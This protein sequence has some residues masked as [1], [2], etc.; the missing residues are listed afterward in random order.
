MKKH[1]LLILVIILITHNVNAQKISEEKTTRWR[2]FE[3]IEF[4]LDSIAAWYVKPKSSIKGNPWIWRAHFPTWHTE[5]DSILLERGFHVAYINTNNLYAHPKAM[6]VWDKFYNYLVNQKNFAP[7][8]ALEGVSRGALYVY[9]WAKRNPDK[10][11]CIYT[12]AAVC[13]FKSWPA[14]KGK[15]KRAVNEWNK[16]LELYGFTEEQ[17]M[18]FNDQ[19]K[20]NL[21]TLA[22]FRVPL[23]HIINLK[24]SIV[25]NEENTF[26]LVNNYL[27]HGG[28][29]TVIP[30]TRGEQELNGH[31]FEIENPQAL[32]DFIY[33]H[34]VPV[35]QLLKS[36]D[37]IHSYGNLNNALFKIQKE[38][39]VTVAF[40][41]GSITNMNGWRNK[42]MQY[43]QELFPQTKFS[44]INA[45]IPSLGSMPHAFRLQR[46]VLDKGKVDLMFIEAAVN[47]KANKTPEL[48]QR[49]ALEG[50]IRHAY[51][52]NPYMNMVVMAFVDEF[53]IA[54]YKE[55]KVPLEVRVHEEIAKYYGLPFINLAKEVSDRIGAKEF[56]WK[57]DFKNLHPSPFGHAIYFN[58]FKTLFQQQWI[59][60]VAQQPIAVKLP[61]P[62]Q[63]TNY[64]NA[65]YVSVDKA[66]NKNKFAIDPSWKPN[67]D[68]K[69]RE[70]FVNVPMLVGTTPGAS[71]DFEF[72]GSAVGIAV[73][74]GPDAGIV[75]YSIDKK[76]EKQ[77]D[78]YNR[79]SAN[80]HLPQYFLLAD[81]LKKGKHKL[82]IKIA[83][84]HNEQSKGN[85]VRI[86]YFLVNH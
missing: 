2:H 55:G 3:K 36:K 53:K 20:D 14:G 81:D 18:Q 6:M 58:T 65:A 35:Q 75:K 46:D 54:E 73:V 22:A 27:R 24:D 50:I 61:E 43:L 5:M 42:T 56:N 30:M 85:A 8:V 83:E 57:D 4:K 21:E 74:A 69:T 28:P 10:V 11:S 70:G 32:A 40:L 84:D 19:P 66:N 9:G 16:L 15:G 45:G 23:L 12:E 68:A 80:L 31:H 77:L 7:K 59:D 17:A 60:K 34:A 62:L 79:Y 37:F 71:F 41:G 72:D 48:Q 39:N 82:S 44:F 51:T 64:T 49:R 63:K 26:V 78:L 86:V 38:K 76:E 29:A 1:A 52:S 67:D 47:D 33:S 13:D 25:P